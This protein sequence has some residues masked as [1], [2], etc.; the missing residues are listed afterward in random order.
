M[1]T[2]NTESTPVADNKYGHPEYVLLAKMEILGMNY[3]VIVFT[4]RLVKS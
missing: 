3:K 2:T 1:A 4:K